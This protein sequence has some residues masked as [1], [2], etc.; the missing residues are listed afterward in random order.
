MLT[1]IKNLILSSL[2]KNHSQHDD[3]EIEVEVRFGSFKKDRFESNV[4]PV[5]YFNLINNLREKGLEEIIEN[6]TVSYFQNKVRKIEI[7]SDKGETIWQTK[8]VIDKIDLPIYEIRFS[9]SSERKL[10]NKEIEK[11]DDE[12]PS[13]IRER[14]RHTFLDGIVKYDITEVVNNTQSSSS[15]TYEIEVEFLDKLDKNNFNEFESKIEEAFKIICGSNTVYTKEEKEGV[16]LTFNNIFDK[17]NSRFRIDKNLFVRPRNIKREDLVSGGIINNKKGKYTVTFKAD[18]KRKILIFN[19]IGI[20]LVN[21]PYEYNLV[22]RIE[23]IIN[24]NL[25]RTVQ[26]LNSFIFDG[27]LLTL[28]VPTAKYTFL[29]MDCIAAK[30]DLRGNYFRERRVICEKITNFF[31][32]NDILQIMTKEVH[33]LDGNNFYDVINYMLDKRKNLP[34]NEDGLIFTPDFPPYC[35]IENTSIPRI[36]P[37]QPDVCK[38]KRVEDMTID[39]AIKWNFDG[40]N[41]SLDLMIFDEVSKKMV[42]FEGTPKNPFNNSMVVYE[43]PILDGLSTGRIVEFEWIQ[44]LNK[45][46][47]RGLRNDKAGS[48]SKTVAIHDWKDIVNPIT[49]DMIRGIGNDMMRSY[50]NRIKREL[51]NKIKEGSNL[52]DIGTGRGGDIG[53]WGK[54]NKVVAVEPNEDNYTE[55]LERLSKSDMSDRVKLVPTGG[56]ETEEITRVVK[57]FFGKADVVSLMLSASFFWSSLD[58]LESLINT[59]IYNIKVGGTIILLTIDGDAVEE[60]FEPVMKEDNYNSISIAGT[61]MLLHPKPEN[62]NSGR[63]LNINIPNSIVGDQ[64]E[65]LVKIDDLVSRLS[66]YGFELISWKPASREDML[67]NESKILSSLY[68]YGIIKQTREMELPSLS[69]NNKS[70]PSF[71]PSFQNDDED[72]EDNDFEDDEDFEDD[73]LEDCDECDTNNNFE[74]DENLKIIPDKFDD[75]YEKINCSWYENF[76][77]FG[78]INSSSLCHAVLKAFY[79]VYQNIYDKKRREELVKNFRHDLALTLN[80]ENSATPGYNFYLTSGKAYFINK[81]IDELV[82]QN[83]IRRYKI[84]YS[85]AGLQSFYNS[86]IDLGEESYEYISEIIDLDIYFVKITEDDLILTYS[87]ASKNRDRKSIIIGYVEKDDVRKYETIGVDNGETFQTFFESENEVIYKLNSVKEKRVLQNFNFKSFLRLKLLSLSEEK[88]NNIEKNISQLDEDD[89]FV[90][91]YREII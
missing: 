39:F 60:L 16:N 10:T 65:W 87:T 84:D 46:S 49:E 31:S 32:Q 71:K 22:F 69:R 34:Y 77:R 9:T 25:K 51:L 37:L 27:E 12:T 78:T 82:D 53:K 74:R 81:L 29:A 76:V 61:E 15:T 62:I 4:P 54:V 67:P 8:M 50:H 86:N 63:V 14:I 41:R 28:K 33:Y 26:A 6:S 3:E 45:F 38:W 89:E 80:F 48:N 59:I 57:K 88:R 44:G 30:K 91:I 70:V 40:K 43:H 23:D 83:N 79:P 21:P 24:A 1:G 5:F 55:F 36:L 90:K 11:I 47:P 73:D 2:K 13:F 58:H 18:G 66:E 72:S 42:N 35:P 20:W 85:L 7:N 19:I 17:S 64:T 52:L 56:G 68:S 75:R